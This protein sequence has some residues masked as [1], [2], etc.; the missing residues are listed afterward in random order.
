MILFWAYRNTFFFILLMVLWFPPPYFCPFFFMF[1][2]SIHF[3]IISKIV[4][5]IFC[6]LVIVVSFVIFNI[7]VYGIKGVVVSISWPMKA[8]TLMIYFSSIS[9]LIISSITTTVYF[10][11]PKIFARKKVTRKETLIPGSKLSPW[12]HISSKL[13]PYLIALYFMLLSLLQLGLSR[14]FSLISVFFSRVL[15]LFS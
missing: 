2:L 14:T 9:K 6:Y 11:M 10:F 5:T 8:S 1:V 3:L 15:W 12:R 4:S 13:V 7:V